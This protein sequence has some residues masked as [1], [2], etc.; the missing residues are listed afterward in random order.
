MASGLAVPDAEPQQMDFF[1][2]GGGILEY[3]VV[4][5]FGI[6]FAISEHKHTAGPAES[7]DVGKEIQMIECDLESLHSP[8]GKASHGAM[9]AIG[10][11]PKVGIDIRDQRQ[12]DIIFKRCG[13]VLHGLQHFG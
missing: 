7:P 10:K 9:I 5:G 12:R 6:E 8:H 2:K 3:A 13:H 4:V 11:C 1:G